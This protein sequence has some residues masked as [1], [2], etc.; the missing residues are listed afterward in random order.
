MKYT[1]VDQFLQVASFA[2]AWIETPSTWRGIN[3]SDVASFAGAWI[4][5]RRVVCR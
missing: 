2:G 4:E 5:T 1:S 3:M